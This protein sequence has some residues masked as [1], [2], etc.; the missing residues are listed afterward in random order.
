M[1]VCVVG[2][3][4]NGLVCAKSMLDQGFSVV[5]LEQLSHLGGLWKYNSDP[6]GFSP[7]YDSLTTNTPKRLT[8]FQGI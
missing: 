6:T 2:A 7:C 8:S 3:G 1:R 4:A 5:V